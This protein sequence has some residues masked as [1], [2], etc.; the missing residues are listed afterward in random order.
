MDSLR[1]FLERFRAGVPGGSARDASVFPPPATPQSEP[2]P[3]RDQV[4]NGAGGFAW[5]VDDW[6][7]LRRFLILGSEGG[8]YHATEATLT[9][10]GACA[11]IRCIA[12]DGRR[13]VD[14][15]VAIS[16]AGRAARND[17]ALFTLA[18]AA[19]LGSPEVRR[20]AHAALPR[21]ARTGTHLLHF[22]AYA[23]SLRGWGRGL[24]EAVAAWYN[25]RPAG[26]AAFQAIKYRQR[27]GWSHRDL[28]RL[29][30]PRAPGESHAALYHW[31]CHGWPG[32]GTDP[33]PDE[34]LRAVWAMERL[35]G[36][37]DP[38]MAATLIREHRLPREA[39]PTPLLG[40]AEVW[41]ALLEQMPVTALI[42]SLAKLTSVGLVT[43]LSAAT[44]H[45][46]DVLGDGERLRRSRIHPV[47][48]LS[49][50][51]TYAQGHGQRGQLTWSPVPAVVRAL[52]RAFYETFS[53]VETTNRRW[54]LALDVSGSMGG[55]LIAGVPGLTPRDASAA[56]AMVTAAREP[57]R[58]IMAFSH[59][60]VPLA[61]GRLQRLDDVV[62]RT[63]A[64]PFGATD[65]ALPMIWAERNRVPVDVFVVYTD[66]ETWCGEIHPFEALRSYRQATGIPAR[67]VVVGM[68]A[69]G[70]TIA[71]PADP[72][73]L[74]VVGFDTATPALMADFAVGAV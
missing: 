24:R 64:L 7:R 27:D 31:I 42:R 25:D 46:R 19:S 41:E 48:I 12:A 73:M 34:A 57:C 71:D 44:R 51:R 5:A 55:S 9:A 22:A 49:A 16:D 30:H 43:P 45:V 59:T 20:H 68:V 60:L 69:N 17:P 18:L 10:E 8:S 37:T 15:T 21:V 26:D 61:I 6:T 23:D 54:L 4:Q 72:G 38:R 39:V 56:M 1:S 40:S 32:V 65:C 14:E 47:A 53:G 33:H 11:T 70:F 67:L 58:H 62:R 74:D 50:L 63:S 28:L 29:A 52:D 3:G 13:V 2:V 35:R 66:S 36:T